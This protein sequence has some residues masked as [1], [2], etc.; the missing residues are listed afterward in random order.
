MPQHIHTTIEQPLGA[1]IRRMYFGDTVND[2]LHL[3]EYQI[4]VEDILDLI[5]L[6]IIVNQLLL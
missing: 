2:I 5:G 3:I 6:N 4:K 1:L